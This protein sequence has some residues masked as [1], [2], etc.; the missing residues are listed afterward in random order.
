VNK[1]W[2]GEGVSEVTTNFRLGSAMRLH[3][4]SAEPILLLDV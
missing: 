1:L 2:E 4:G 3:R